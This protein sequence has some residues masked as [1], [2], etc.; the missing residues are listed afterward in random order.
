[1]LPGPL[2]QLVEEG[3]RAI[4]CPND[5]LAISLLVLLGNAI[6]NSRCLHIKTTWHEG[7]R[8]WAAIVGQPGDKKSPALELAARPYKREQRRLEAEWK[9]AY[10]AWKAAEDP[11]DQEE[12]RMRRIATTD[13]TVE[14]LADLL[15]ENDRGILYMQDELAGWALAM[16]QYKGGKGADRKHWLSFW[17]ANE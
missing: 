12:P 1:V 8:L 15:A 10:K 4:H 6:G 16:N 11:G 3:A 14:A 13:A 17:T 2:R 7:P 9:V 5:Y